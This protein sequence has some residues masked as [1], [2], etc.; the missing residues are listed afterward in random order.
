MSKSSKPSKGRQAKYRRTTFPRPQYWNINYTEK[1]SCGSE[2]DFKTIIFARSY[3]LAVHMLEQKLK[4]PDP[5]LKIKAVHGFMFHK[6][7]HSAAIG[8]LGVKEWE[9]IRRS[10]FP[11][12]NNFLFKLEIPRPEGYTNRFNKT[13]FEQLK[14][15]GF[16]KGES[17]WSVRNR[18]G[19]TLPIE[20]RTHKTWKGRWVD[21][22]PLLRQAAK[23]KL[24]EALIKS[25]NNRTHA[26]KYLGV[27]R[28]KIYKLFRKFPE[29]DWEK[30]YP[31]PPPPRPSVSYSYSMKKRM[32]DGEV[33][34]E[35]G[36]S[37]EAQAKRITNMTRAKRAKRKETIEEMLPKIDSALKETG[38]NRS[39]ASD[40]LGLSPSVFGKLLRA[41]QDQINWSKKYPSKFANKRYET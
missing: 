20:E 6:D 39:K 1:H 4:E 40:L 3:N 14:N 9:E 2:K 26:A 34:F 29:V 37:P 17:N 10:A 32:D 38:G 33:P 27:H 12:E 36:Q 11:N 24:M 21:W 23:H 22:D 5:L 35:S 16:S 31:A 30:E 28:N 15:I 7:Y 8:R 41:T 19:K 13:D 18:K 25:K